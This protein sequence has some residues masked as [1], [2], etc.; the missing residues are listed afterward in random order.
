MLGTC[1]MG[2]LCLHPSGLHEVYAVESVE[3]TRR[4][5]VVINNCACA[6]HQPMFSRIIAGQN[7]VADSSF[8]AQSRTETP[9]HIP[10]NVHVLLRWNKPCAGCKTGF[11]P[12]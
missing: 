2:H 6:S 8:I 10:S 1:V 4:G 9:L 5:V 7:M 11:A 3:V 12:L